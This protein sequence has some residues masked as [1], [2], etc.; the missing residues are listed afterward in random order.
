MTMNKQELKIMKQAIEKYGVNNQMAKVQEE[1]AELIQAISKLKRSGNSDHPGRTAKAAMNKL[2]EEVA[3]VQ[4][5]LD[6]IKLMY[7]SNAYDTIR[8]EKLA[9]LEKRMEKK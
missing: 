9:R 3:D 5:M 6:Q 1:C 4:I 8:T 7:P 2:Y